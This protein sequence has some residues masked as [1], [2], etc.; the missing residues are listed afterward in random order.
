MKMLSNFSGPIHLV[1]VAWLLFSGQLLSWSP[2]V[3][4]P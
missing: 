3:L 1:V 2:Y 4:M